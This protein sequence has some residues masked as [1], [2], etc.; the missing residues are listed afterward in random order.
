MKH[1]ILQAILNTDG[2]FSI[3]SHPGENSFSFGL[4]QP[5]WKPKKKK[6]GTKFPLRSLIQDSP[7]RIGTNYK[8][9]AKSSLF[10]CAEL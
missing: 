3:L 6:S 7:V 1:A 5:Q 10:G 4:I 2:N 9:E 8:S